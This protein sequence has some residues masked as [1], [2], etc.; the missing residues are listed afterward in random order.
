MHSQQYM[1]PHLVTTASLASSIHTL[2]SH[3][4][5]YIIITLKII[6]Q[7]LKSIV[8][9]NEQTQWLNRVSEETFTEVQKGLQKYKDQQFGKRYKIPFRVA[10]VLFCLGAGIQYYGF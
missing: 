3:F 4:V 10:K 2:H 7:N 9:W 1:C 5:S 8:N 6:M